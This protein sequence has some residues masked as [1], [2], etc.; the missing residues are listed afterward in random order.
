LVTFALGRGV[1]YY[2]APA[3]RAILRDAESDDYRFSSP[4]IATAGSF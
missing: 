2:D 1:D 4:R 3:I